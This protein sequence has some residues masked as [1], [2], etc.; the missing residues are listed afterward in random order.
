MKVARVCANYIYAGRLQET[1]PQTGSPWTGGDV[2]TVFFS[3]LIGGMSLGQ[4]GPGIQSLMDARVAVSKMSE[5]LDRK[6]PINVTA[7]GDQPKDFVQ[8]IRFE[9]VR[10]TYPSA[11]DVE[12]LKGVDFEIPA[13]KFV[14]LV[15]PSGSGKSTII[16]LIERFFDPTVGTV[17]C[18]N[19]NHAPVIQLY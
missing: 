12:V 2:L 13:G 4:A 19:L 5:T 10:F 15:G 9:N 16:Q 1:N 7:G 8:P 6:P 14:A 11:P 17:K 18:V 3:V